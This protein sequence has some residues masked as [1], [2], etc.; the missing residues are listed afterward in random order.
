M[1]YLKKYNRSD[2]VREYHSYVCNF[3]KKYRKD[4]CL[5][6]QYIKNADFSNIM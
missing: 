3:V 5:L 4:A 1:Y 6:Y 2:A